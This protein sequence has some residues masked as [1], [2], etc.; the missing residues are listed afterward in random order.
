MASAHVEMNTIT[1]SSAVSACEKGSQWDQALSLLAEMAS[2]H[3]EMNTITYNAA[4]SA[5]EKGGQWNQGLRLLVQMVS[6]RGMRACGGDGVCPIGVGR[7]HIQ[8]RSQC[9][10]NRR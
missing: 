1:L 7:H 8:C 6:A 10:R 4:V 5:C 2:A 9:I 3:V